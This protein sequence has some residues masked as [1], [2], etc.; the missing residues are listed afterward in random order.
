MPMYRVDDSREGLL[1][2]NRRESG[3]QITA[4]SLCRQ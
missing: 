1:T 2:V 4:G 3:G